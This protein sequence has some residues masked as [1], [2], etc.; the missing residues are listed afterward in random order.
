MRRLPARAAG[1]ARGR[2]AGVVFMA[3]SLIRGKEGSPRAAAAGWGPAPLPLAL[4]AGWEGAGLRRR[5]GGSRPCA[6]RHGAGPL[7]KGAWRQGCPSRRRAWAAGSPRAW[8]AGAPPA[9]LSLGAGVRRRWGWR[10]AAGPAGSQP[11]S[12]RRPKGG[13]PQEGAKSRDGGKAGQSRGGAG[14]KRGVDSCGGGGG[15]GQGPLPAAQGV[16]PAHCSAC[17]RCPS[18]SLS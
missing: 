18:R 3:L 7:P 2:R 5:M 6:R 14:R 13:D 8:A 11:L 12:G 15:G 16:R 1:R 10:R 9:R 17:G 4:A